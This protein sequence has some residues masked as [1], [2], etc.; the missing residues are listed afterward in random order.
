[1]DIFILG[2]DSF[3]GLAL[4]REL[5]QKG[6][7]IVGLGLDQLPHSSACYESR[8]RL[9]PKNEEA[10][11]QV[12]I[13]ARR[14]AS[15][16]KL[17][18]TDHPRAGYFLSKR[19]KLALYLD[20]PLAMDPPLPP[21]S[22]QSFLFN[23][24]GL[25]QIK[26]FSSLDQ[27]GLTYPIKSLKTL[28]VYQARKDVPLEDSGPFQSYIQRAPGKIRLFLAYFDPAGDLL[29]YGSARGYGSY[30]LEA[31]A[32]TIFQTKPDLLD[33]GLLS[34]ARELQWRGYLSITTKED[35]YT[36]KQYVLSMK[37]LPG[38]FSFLFQRA[39]LPL[40]QALIGDLKSREKMLEGQWGRMGQ[41]SY[42]SLYQHI[43]KGKILDL[44]LFTY[45][46]LRSFGPL[47][48]WQDP[49][50]GISNSSQTLDLL[51]QGLKRRF[52]ARKGAPSGGA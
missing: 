28:T 49:G 33:A 40:G 30:P 13:L 52:R 8:L 11:E 1:M 14:R 22:V 36:K 51:Y 37:T 35:P 27:E 3:A 48:S 24:Y 16:P 43:K 25:D 26:T 19:E 34:L 38:P 42:L 15:R 6:H 12:L 47:W 20:L 7:A 4:A 41:A 2:A 5:A 45:I 29:F 50:V 10:L 44:P 32:P 46:P 39:G 23:K 9:S 31:D 21:E 17:V 18:F